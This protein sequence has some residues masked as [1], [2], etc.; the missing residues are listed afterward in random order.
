MR[1]GEEEG[2]IEGKRNSI[3]GF[4]LAF[5][6]TGLFNQILR[7][8]LMFRNTYDYTESLLYKTLLALW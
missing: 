8:K 7:S 5:R 3:F 6:E 1:L 4:M 2:R